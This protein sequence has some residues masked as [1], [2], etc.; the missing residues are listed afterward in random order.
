MIL[1]IFI[2]YWDC[3]TPRLS[4]TAYILKNSSKASQSFISTFS[5]IIPLKS[6]V[7]IWERINIST[8]FIGEL[9]KVKSPLQFR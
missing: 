4:L 3:K 7:E 5:G 9:S 1:Y 6:A 2:T 8:S